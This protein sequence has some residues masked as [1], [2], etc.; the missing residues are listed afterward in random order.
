MR[1]GPILLALALSSSGCTL[2]L[3]RLRGARA[4]AGGRDAPGLDAPP[5]DAPGA[6]VPGLDAP[7]PGD[8]P[9][10]DAPP[11]PLTLVT[12]GSI[13]L[14][15]ATGPRH[16][17]LLRQGDLGVPIVVVSDPTA[18]RVRAWSLTRTECT[19][20]PTS[21]LDQ[22]VAGAGPMAYLDLDGDDLSDLAVGGTGAVALFRGT[23][24]SFVST[25][26]ALHALGAPSAVAAGSLD[27]DANPDVAV[28]EAGVRVG[29][30]AG[31]GAGTLTTAG[32]LSGSVV[33]RDGAAFDLDGDG[34]TDLVGVGGDAPA[35]TFQSFPGTASLFGAPVTAGVGSASNALAVGTL[36]GGLV[37]VTAGGGSIALVTVLGGSARATVAEGIGSDLVDVALADLDGDGANEIV[38][39]DG[40]ASMVRVLSRAGAGAFQ[41]AQIR[42]GDVVAI[43]AADLDGDGVAEVAALVSGEIVFVGPGC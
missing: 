11:P 33:L 2:D 9:P 24:S 38:V 18:G 37:A 10:G 5:A 42:V 22:G 36:G 21:V 16:V 15:T 41:R 35:G 3:E 20:A 17:L 19:W 29:L 14:G 4:D 40:G 7:V 6:D 8:A 34:H 31:T 43:D 12:Q 27:A 25:G 26:A 30:F 13:G 39:A 1:L 32:T 28:F 23:A